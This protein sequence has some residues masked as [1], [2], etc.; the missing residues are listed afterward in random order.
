MNSAFYECLVVLVVLFPHLLLRY[1][2]FQ[3]V[4]HLCYV[5]FVVRLIPSL[6]APEPC[7]LVVFRDEL[8]FALPL[9]NCLVPPLFVLV[10]LQLRLQ[11]LNHKAIFE[12]EGIVGGI[13]GGQGICIVFSAVN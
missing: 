8:K 12:V 1:V 9:F 13:E 2:V 5:L 4:L 11:L 7:S 10:Q 6:D 3:C